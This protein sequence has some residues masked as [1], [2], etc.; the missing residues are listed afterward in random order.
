MCLASREFFFAMGLRLRSICR[1]GGG[2]KS[3]LIDK[4]PSA[5]PAS[6]IRCLGGSKFVI[7]MLC[8]Y[9]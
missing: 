9:M 1:G 2:V 5:R 8:I 7:V 3:S 6:K 4:E